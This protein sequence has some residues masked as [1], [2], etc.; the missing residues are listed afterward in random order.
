MPG[1]SRIA[2]GHVVAVT[3]DL[4]ELARRLRQ[5]DPN[6]LN[7]FCVEASRDYNEVEYLSSPIW[8]VDPSSGTPPV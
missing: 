4:N 2:N 6:P 8:E 1:D 3:D 5:A 7:T